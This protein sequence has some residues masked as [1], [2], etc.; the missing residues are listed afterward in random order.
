MGI[1]GITFLSPEEIAWSGLSDSQICGCNLASEHHEPFE[2][3]IY[4]IGQTISMFGAGISHSM[5]IIPLSSQEVAW[6]GFLDLCE[7]LSCFHIMS[8]L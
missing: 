7:L 1:K 4:C 2:K 3:G 8:Y 6:S 5:D